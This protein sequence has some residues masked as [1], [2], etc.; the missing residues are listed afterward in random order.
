MQNKTPISSAVKLVVFSVIFL[1]FLQCNN[2]NVTPYDDKYSEKPLI[3]TSIS[4]EKKS[5]DA[6]IKTLSVTQLSEVPTLGKLQ[7][8]DR[9]HRKYRQ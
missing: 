3:C 8:I 1:N 4:V 5:F 6:Y 9:F 7:I 2:I